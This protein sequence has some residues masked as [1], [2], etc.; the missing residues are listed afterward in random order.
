MWIKYILR[1]KQKIVSCLFT[2]ASCLFTFVSCLFT[3]L[4]MVVQLIFQPN[5]LDGE[6]LW[7]HPL[8]FIQLSKKRRK[9]KWIALFQE[10]TG[11]TLELTEKKMVTP[12]VPTKISWKNGLLLKK[13]PQKYLVKKTHA[14]KK[15]LL[16]THTGFYYLHCQVNQSTLTWIYF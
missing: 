5:V 11:V 8:T 15:M 6:C 10:N 16:L 14:A 2:F 13:S 9:R 7:S 1:C 12:K 4:Q 3:F